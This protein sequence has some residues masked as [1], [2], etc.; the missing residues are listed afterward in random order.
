MVQRESRSSTIGHITLGM[1]QTGAPSAG[2]PHA[3]CDVAG[4]GNGFTVWL[5]R[6]SQRKRGET[7]RPDLRNTAP[8]LDPTR[9][10]RG[11]RGAGNLLGIRLLA[12]LPVLIGMEGRSGWHV[13]QSERALSDG[14]K[15]HLAKRR[16]RSRVYRCR[17]RTD[18]STGATRQRDP[19]WTARSQAPRQRRVRLRFG[20]EVCGKVDQIALHKC[21]VGTNGR[22][23]TRCNPL[24]L[25]T[26]GLGEIM[27]DLV[28]IRLV[29]IPVPH[30]LIHASAVEKAVRATDQIVEM[31]TENRTWCWE[32]CCGL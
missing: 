30:D 1:K 9:S 7:D 23:R 27:L 31:A 29:L 3:G 16:Q 13:G 24:R 5:L 11:S 28:Q 8:V 25:R 22:Q 19:Q 14:I 15:L 32:F 21:G 17:A 26:P 4:A 2:N 6:H 20:L 10:G 18:E 12:D